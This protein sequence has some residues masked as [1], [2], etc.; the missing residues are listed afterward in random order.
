MT[1]AQLLQALRTDSAVDVTE[2]ADADLWRWIYSAIQEHN[3]DLD[4]QDDANATGIENIGSVHIRPIVL[5]SQISICVN[6]AAKAS[7]KAAIVHLEG[8]MDWSAIVR[9]NLAL[10]STLREEYDSYCEANGLGNVSIVVSELIRKMPLDTA[11]LSYPKVGDIDAPVLTL[12]AYDAQTKLLKLAWTTYGGN[13]FWKY[14]ILYNSEDSFFNPSVH[15]ELSRE[16]DESATLLAEYGDVR[17]RGVDVENVEV[18]TFFCVAVYD[19]AGRLAFSNSV[20]VT[21]S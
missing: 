4:V 5:L 6:R 11:V 3:S 7:K 19:I 20:E 13:L 10:V 21:A 16:V 12:A 18:G 9:N 15:G 2:Y 14:K 1:K 17:T 8:S